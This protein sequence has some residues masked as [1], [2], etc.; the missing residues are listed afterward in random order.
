[1]F[2]DTWGRPGARDC[3]A[4]TTSKNPERIEL[5]FLRAMDGAWLP[6]EVPGV[7]LGEF[8][9]PS[10]GVSITGKMYVLFTTDHSEKKTMGRSV[11]AVS[12]DG[13]RHF[14]RLYDFSTERFINVAFWKA[15]SWLYIFGSGDYRK[16][17]VCLARV[18]QDKIESRGALEYHI[19]GG[20]NGQPHWS[21][22]ESKAQPL[23]HHDVVGEL[24]VAYCAPLAHY[25]MLYNSSKPRG[26]VMRSAP[27]PWGPWSDAT[28]IFDPGKD[29]GYGHFMH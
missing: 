19:A 24:S 6:L 2:G 17:S 16:S 23:F 10:H 28:V 20:P 21:P 26:I 22:S 13:G 4:W 9:V 29:N 1:L 12:Q 7:S 25:V 15:D 11:L 3:L 14:K 18:Q 27:H 5:E 8:E